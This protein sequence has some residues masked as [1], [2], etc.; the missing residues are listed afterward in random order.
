MNL[1]VTGGAG[2]IGS[3]LIRHLIDQPEI[4]KLINLDCLTYAGHLASLESISGHTKY[5]FEKVDLRD[6]ASVMRVIEHRRHLPPARSLPR[7]MAGF[8]PR[9]SDCGHPTPLPP[10]FH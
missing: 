9:T 10:R 7:E 1:L 2:F 8:G 6:K 4:G 5:A 3:N